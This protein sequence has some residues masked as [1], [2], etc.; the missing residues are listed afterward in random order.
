MF[1]ILDMFL[2]NSV[3]LLGC[4]YAHIVLVIFMQRMTCVLSV[5]HQEV[6]VET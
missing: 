4:F 3:L 6:Q 1:C 5:E 2:R